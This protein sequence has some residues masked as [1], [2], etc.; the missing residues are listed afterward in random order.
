LSEESIGTIVD[1]I[2]R[3]R[4]LEGLPDGGQEE[5]DGGTT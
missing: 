1:M 3:V 4:Q 2:E 5:P